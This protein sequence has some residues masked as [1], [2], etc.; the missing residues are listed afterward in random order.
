MIPCCFLSALTVYFWS[1]AHDLPSLLI[2]TTVY[3]FI[4]GGMVS[5][6]A[7]IIANLTN[8]PS[9]YGTRIGMSFTVGAVGALVGGPIAGAMRKLSTGSGVSDAQGEYRGIWYFAAST[10]LFATALMV[11]A[12]SL[13]LGWTW[14]GKI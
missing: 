3:G 5:L 11:L 8:H 13:K 7:A 6:P 12:R 9:E 2:I 1:Y 4:S 14:K 10:M